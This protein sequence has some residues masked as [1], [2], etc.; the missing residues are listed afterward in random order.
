MSNFRIKKTFIRDLMEGEIIS[1][2]DERGYFERV[3]C[4][5]EFN[6]I[7]NLKKSIIQ[8]NRSLSKVKGT[9]RGCHFQLPPFAEIKIVSCPKGSLFDVGIDLRKGS[10]TYLKH[11]SQILSA[12]NK[13]F[14]IIPEGFAHGF[15]TLEE[16]TE[17]LYLVTQEFSLKHDNGINPFD[18]AI[19]INWPIPCTIRSEKDTKRKF[20]KD[21]NFLGINLID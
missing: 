11:Y 15:Q 13:K 1:R 20:I 14:L 4:I 19:N 8:I 18:P 9:I 7:I 10:P 5:N 6:E 16:N 21:R 12:E 3:Y 17:I 2:K